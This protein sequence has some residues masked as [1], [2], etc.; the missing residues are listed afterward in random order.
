MADPFRGYQHITQQ[1]RVIYTTEDKLN[2]FKTKK[3]LGLKV[4]ELEGEFT[5]VADKVLVLDHEGVVE[6]QSVF[7]ELGG[8]QTLRFKLK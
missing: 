4:I 7:D 6:V 1:T 3:L 8:T 2:E 5:N